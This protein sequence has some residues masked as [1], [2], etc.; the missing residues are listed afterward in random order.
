M[1][2]LQTQGF[3]INKDSLLKVIN[4]S[5]SP[6]TSKFYAYYDLSWDYLYTDLDSAYMF[7][8]K[9]YGLLKKSKL[10]RQQPKI[11][12]LLGACFQVKGDYVQAIGYYQQSLKYGERTKN[13]ETILTAYSNIGALYIQLN[14]F[15]KA[16]EYQLKALPIA[17]KNKVITSLPSIYNNLCLIYNNFGDSKK[18]LQYGL[19]S[20]LL[21]RQLNNK[22]GICSATGN[23]GNAYLANKEYDK[24]LENFQE[25]YKVAGEI[26]NYY[27][28][29]R[30]VLDI[31]DIYKIKNQNSEALKY[32][33]I[34]KRI[35]EDNEDYE[36]TL[37]VTKNLYLIYKKR[38]EKLKALENFELYVNL[39]EQINENLRKEEVNKRELEFE[40]N[41]R[42]VRDSIKNAEEAKIKDLQLLA[43][44]SQIE[45]DK[46]F[47]IGLSVVLL[48]VVAFGIII[49]NRFRI[50]S[51]QKK[52]IEL[53][54]KQTQEQK[55]IIENKNKEILD[56]INYAQ[57]IQLALLANKKLLNDAIK[58]ENYFIFFKPKDIV[59]GDFYWA[60]RVN[61][62]FYLAVCD[63]T[64]HGVPGAFMSLLNMSFLSEAIKE[65]AI[66]EPNKVFNYVR[67]RL[68]ET[69]SS[70]GQQD[71]FDGILICMDSITGAISYAAANNSPMVVINNSSDDQTGI[72]QQL[73]YDKMPVGKGEKNMDFNLYTIPQP[74]N[75]MLYLNTDGYADQ[76]GGPNRKKFRT[77]QLHEVLLNSNHQ[78]CY[79]QLI[80]IEKK[81]MDWKGN[82]DQIDDVCL[83]GIKL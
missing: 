46:L 25:C 37:E 31:G 13:N 82:L 56:S 8:K 16:L 22:N 15:Q 7:A 29:G 83:I 48:L 2:F 67:S 6:D 3:S 54:E 63:S 28:Q 66:Y 23:I 78:T 35:S 24:A 43:N 65:K 12:N 81:F 50:I 42:S 79:R 53:K 69:I 62:L 14:Q 80:T 5:V 9:A 10:T 72:L 75:K 52:I 59:S 36:T 64:G 17:E 26:G 4:N 49:F 61:H 47:K 32:F 74:K 18:A 41:K 44:K 21:Y 58:E 55:D 60:T 45:K 33:L 11:T 40:F 34:A 68:I 76:F 77:R 1:V 19:K 57:R 70:E 20:L 51:K 27:E 30:A 38:G 71:G 73:P 39:K